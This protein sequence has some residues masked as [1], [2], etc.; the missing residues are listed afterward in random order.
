MRAELQGAKSCSGHFNTLIEGV[1]FIKCLS[2]ECLSGFAVSPSRASLKAVLYFSF[3]RLFQET[4][5]PEDL[6]GETAS[7]R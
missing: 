1:G 3:Q 6:S 5:H 2:L 4:D 7:S